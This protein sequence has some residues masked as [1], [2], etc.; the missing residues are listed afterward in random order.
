MLKLTE[1]RLRK[2]VQEEIQSVVAGTSKPA[3]RR[4]KLSEAMDA[5]AGRGGFTAIA[6]V[7]FL[8]DEGLSPGQDITDHPTIRGGG[9]GRRG[10]RLA[11]EHRR[12]ARPLKA[13]VTSDTYNGEPLIKFT[14]RSEENARNWFEAVNDDF[15]GDWEYQYDERDGAV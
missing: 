7:N 2:I 13:V 1:S 15:D 9:G 5:P 4:S 8:V 12:I 6:T 11:G 14:F 10:T 3:A